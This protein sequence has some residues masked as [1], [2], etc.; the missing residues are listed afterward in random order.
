M[1]ATSELSAEQAGQ[2][3]AWRGLALT[4]MPYMASILFSLRPVSA[5]GLGT[6]AVDKH[7]R[8][9]V[10][11]DAVASK[12]A[13][14]CAEG[15][16]HECCH[17][18]GD[19]AA[20]AD[21]F[22]VKPE[23]A[24]TWNVAADASINDDL[25]DAGCATLAKV[26]VLPEHF[27]LEDDQTAE[28]YMRQLADRMPKRPQGGQGG[29]CGSGAGAAPE[30]C[31]VDGPEAS[32]TVEA[33]ASGAEAERARIA[34]AAHIRQ[35]AGKYP[36]SV[37]GGL[38]EMAGTILA[39]PKV[40]WR[41][42]LA[43]Y[44]RRYVAVAAG[45]TDTTYMRRRRRLPSL[46]LG[47]G[48]RVIMPGSISPKLSL[49]VVRDTSGS[50]GEA[51]LAATMS[52]IEGIARQ[53]GVSGPDLVVLDTDTEV[54]AKRGYRGAASIADVHGRGGTDMGPGIAA[55]AQLRPRPLAVIVLTDGYTPWPK[56]KPAIPVIVCLVGPGAEQTASE[57]PDWA[58]TVVAT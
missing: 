26:G 55:A 13:R 3:A 42:V 19:H 12:G 56:K 54:A 51:E 50:M 24:Q 5:P 17:L 53:A 34:T 20:R 41:Q 43:A 1:R 47:T 21:A 40:P 33:G 35:Q 30:P 6:F 57:V 48:D 32:G 23:D 52:E 49:A 29:G 37:P 15:L 2:L 36:G 28:F 58:A 27:G 10:D 38:V 11:F 16:L 31:E 39:P 9:Y 45:N 46:S 18:L 14:F 44:V 8:L 7:H 4:I 25:R 22:G